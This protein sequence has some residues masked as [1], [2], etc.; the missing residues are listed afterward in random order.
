MEKRTIT[1]L[2]IIIL[3]ISSL[4][5]AVRLGYLEDRMSKVEEVQEQWKQPSNTF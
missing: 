5:H 2:T 4:L 1:Q 3:A